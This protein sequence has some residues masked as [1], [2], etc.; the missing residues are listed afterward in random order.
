M[1]IPLIASYVCSRKRKEKEKGMYMMLAAR[2]R[3][4]L[5]AFRDR[6]IN[7]VYE[8]PKDAQRSR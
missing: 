8:V 6:I 4:A 7:T 1:T 2:Q 5:F 3:T